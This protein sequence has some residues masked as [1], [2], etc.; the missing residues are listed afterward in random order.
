MDLAIGKV[1]I[2]YLLGPLMAEDQPKE[3]EEYR[4]VL[5]DQEGNPAEPV[6]ESTEKPTAE[7]TEKSAGTKEVHVLRKDDRTGKVLE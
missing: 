3:Y 6:V 7:P 1:E 2:K 4:G 5:V